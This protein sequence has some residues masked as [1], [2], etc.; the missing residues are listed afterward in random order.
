MATSIG[1]DIGG[2]GIKG[3]VVELDDGEFVGERCRIPTPRPA[4]PE[5]VAEVVAEVVATLDGDGPVGCTLPAVVRDGVAESAANIDDAWIGT[6]GEA[7]IGAATGRPTTL[8]NDADAAGLAEQRFGAARGH[9][10]VVLVLT[11]GTG[12]GSGLLVDG[13]LVPNTELGHLEL[14]G[15]DAESRAAASVRKSEHLS[16]PKWAQR[17]DRYLH[18]VE[19]LFS[20]DLF[21]LG[22]G[23]SRKHDRFMPLLTVDTEVVPAALRNRAGIV[24]AAL[25]ATQA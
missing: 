24:G 9:G 20:P 10:G 4:T 22:G 1:I 19:D 23:V 15:H 3:A 12:I 14:D 16:W 2:S 18:H 13:R 25:R 11:L 6:D 21:V 5:A 8:L 17:L 7:L